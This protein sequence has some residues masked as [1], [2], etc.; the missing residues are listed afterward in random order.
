MGARGGPVKAATPSLRLGLVGCGRLAELG[1]TPASRAADGIE[2]VAVADPERTRRGLVADKLGASG[3]A[4]MSEM[5]AATPLHGLIVC[6]PAEQH[7]EATT[8]AAH[9]GLTVLVEK[10]PAPDAEGALRL[11]ALSPEPWIA[12]NRRFDQG[13]ELARRVPP[14]GEL[15]LKMVLHY[16]RDSWR[17]VQRG[18]DALLDL[19]PH[20]I[21]L[22]LFLTRSAPV[23]VRAHAT[24]DRAGIV[25]ATTRAEVQIECATDRPHQELVEVRTAGGR[26]LGR[27]TSAGR[28]RGAVARLSPA[29][30]PLVRSLTRQLE[31]YGAAL[32][33]EDPGPLATAGEGAAVM[34]VLDAA[35]RSDAI[36]GETVPV[37][38]VTVA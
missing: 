3:H 5:L 34:R 26:L 1:Y 36:G 2:I 23:A 12:F 31:A 8:L 18:D 33:G 16:R 35:R 24:R 32:R 28:V 30:H 13:S 37:E 38:G 7:E 17:P 19:G 15:A 29:A 27:T 20:L 25:L 22:A 21:D 10:P 4:R 11:A 6:T 9:A 14:G